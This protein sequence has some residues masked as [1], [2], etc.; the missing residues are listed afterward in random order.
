VVH[1][2]ITKRSHSRIPA[3]K[4]LLLL[5]RWY[6]ARTVHRTVL[7]HACFYE[8]NPPLSAGSKFNVLGSKFRDPPKISKQQA[9]MK[10]AFRH[11]VGVAGVD[12]ELHLGKTH[13][14]AW[15][16]TTHWS[17]IIA[18]RDAASPAS[19]AALQRLCRTYWP[20]VY[21][22]IRR[23]GFG[24]DDSKD[25]TQEFLSR[26]VHKEWLTHLKHQDGRFRN[27][28]LTVVKHFLSDERD[29]ANAQK[30][31]GGKPLISIDACHEEERDSLVCTSTFT[32]QE[33]FERRWAETVMTEAAERLR[34]SYAARGKSA[35]FEQL[36]DLQPGEHGERSYAQ[37]AAT[38][39]M[40]EQAMKNAV[41]TFRRR[42]AQCLRDE[43]AQTVSNPAE[44]EEELRHLMS[45]FVR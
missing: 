21:A 33:I 18:A 29:R 11:D 3:A 12:S 38:L 19:T 2:E 40:S 16:T 15:F 35:L 8:T 13:T 44:V 4:T 30:R 5:R 14:R 7:H 36:K 27:F 43:I 26:L 1:P 9:G 23:E 20:P 10:G 39:G 28:L 6:A 34:R 45:L 17:V 41:L 31:G 25:L 42:Y 24:A 22:F 37:I 32:P